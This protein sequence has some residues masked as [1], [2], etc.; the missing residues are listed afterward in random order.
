MAKSFKSLLQSPKLEFLMEAH[1]GLSARIVEETGFSGIWASGLSISA[2]YGVRDCNEASWTQ[3]VET[4]EFMSECTTIPILMDADTGFGNF[5]N[6]IRLVQKLEKIEIAG[7]CI[8][9][10]LFPKINSLVKGFNQPLASIGEFC[11][12]I[13]AAKDTQKNKDFCVIARTE[14][15]VTGYKVE[16]AIKR[17]SAYAEAGADG[18]LVHSKLDN[19]SE[20]IEFVKLW[21]K[22]TPL[23]IV[24]TT[25]NSTP[26]KLFRE[27][28]ISI[29]IWAN[30]NVR[31][32]ITAMR[33]IS[34]RIYLDSTTKEIESKIAKL[35]DIFQLTNMLEL[36][37]SEEKY[38]KEFHDKFDNVLSSAKR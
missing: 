9:D 6:V 19:P 15:F 24:P 2:S 23:I 21:Q 10:K 28:G 1:N 27:L 3:I 31:A 36:K 12:K 29:V 8:E 30:H 35:D 33:E 13:N 26:T 18:I 25:Y 7:I 22:D 16:E 37:I 34:K 11:G 32:C 14:A 38:L 5:N 17:A 20:I 4:L